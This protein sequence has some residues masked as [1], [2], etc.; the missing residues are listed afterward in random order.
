MNQVA[1]SIKYVFRGVI[2]KNQ[3][4]TNFRISLKYIEMNRIIIKHYIEYYLK[5]QDNRNQ[6]L[7][8]PDKQRMRIIDWYK[9]IKKEVLEEEY[10]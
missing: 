6:K 8:D 3:T 9:N 10:L 7:Y 1:I 4:G 2:I 5:Y